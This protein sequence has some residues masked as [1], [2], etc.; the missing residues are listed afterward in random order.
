M[1]FGAGHELGLLRF[2]KDGRLLSASAGSARSFG[3]EAVEELV[4]VAGRGGLI[5]ARQRAELLAAVR[6]AGLG[7]PISVDVDCVKRDESAWTCRVA[8]LLASDESVHVLLLE[9][10]AYRAEREAARAREPLEGVL[11]GLPNPVFVNDFLDLLG[12][13]LRNPLN[14]IRVAVALLRRTAAP[15]PTTPRAQEIIERQ[16]AQLARLIDDLLDV[17]RIGRGKVLLR[18]ERVDLVALVRTVLGDREES[19]RAH[20]IV[21][22]TSLPRRPVCV[23]ADP[24]RL[25]QVVGNLIDNAEKFTDPAGLITVAI[26]ADPGFEAGSVRSGTDQRLERGVSGALSGPPIGSGLVAVSVRDSGIGMSQATLTTLF[27]PFV[28][29]A[30][31]VRRSGGL[32]LGLSLVRGLMELHGGSATAFSEGEGRG[33]EFVIRLPLAVGEASTGAKAAALTARRILVIE[34]NADAAE[35]L[36]MVLS[37]SGHQVVVAG[38]GE[39]G[40]ERAR[41][42]HPRVVLSDIGLPGMNGYEV[43]RILRSDPAFAGMQLIAITGFGQEEDQERAREAGFDRHLTKPFDMDALEQVLASLSQP[44]STASPA[45]A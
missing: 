24:A 2:G 20:G 1:R 15:D 38:S 17:S 39:E 37:A 30:R 32:G 26:E 5:D 31:G 7:V 10:V 18:K 29:E 34:D 43:A 4:S 44:L 12:H 41:A 33:S 23:D 3:F 11:N 21:L 19:L 42:F 22:A 25:A 8:A 13:E 45:V 6:A 27:Q 35:A 14:P 16:V 9:D 28:Q 40:I 36:D